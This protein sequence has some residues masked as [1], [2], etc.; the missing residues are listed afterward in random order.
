[1]RWRVS[2]AMAF[3]KSSKSQHVTPLT[4]SASKPLF[5]EQIATD[6]QRARTGH[7]DQH[8]STAFKQITGFAFEVQAQKFQCTLG[9]AIHQDAHQLNDVFVF[10]HDAQV[11]FQGRLAFIIQIISYSTRITFLRSILV[12]EL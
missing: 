5:L 2:S 9:I 12:Q 4:A 10:H 6:L 11:L 8:L 1:M 3:V 7:F